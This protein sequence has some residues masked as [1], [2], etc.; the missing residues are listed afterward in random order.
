MTKTFLQFI[1]EKTDELTKMLKGSKENQH[2]AVEHPNLQPHHIDIALD[3]KKKTGDKSWESVA[4]KAARHPN[5]S[6]ENLDKALEHHDRNVRKNVASHPNAQEHHL[7]KA[8]DDKDDIVVARALKHPNAPKDEVEKHF[9]GKQKDKHSDKEHTAFRYH[10]AA[11]HNMNGKDPKI[12][13]YSH[14]KIEAQMQH[15]ASHLRTQA[16][17]HPHFTAK[18]VD[19]ALK[20]DNSQL[21]LNAIRHPSATKDHLKAALNH[22]DPYVR[23]EASLI[24]KGKN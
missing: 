12:A 14:A 7:R 1:S 16:A 3:A 24:L 22:K 23:H 9:F 21:A 15:P 20:G 18:H 2:A 11:A 19:M 5:A 13:A 17:D 4:E 6:S 10:A 8:I